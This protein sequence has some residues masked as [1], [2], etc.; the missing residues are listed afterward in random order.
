MSLVIIGS[1]LITAEFMFIIVTDSDQSQ[2]SH[3]QDSHT[4][5]SQIVTPASNFTPEHH[6]PG[7]KMVFFILWWYR[8]FLSD[9]PGIK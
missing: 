5:K 6:N 8:Y 9:Y 7:P 1:D 4:C 2:Q 3:L